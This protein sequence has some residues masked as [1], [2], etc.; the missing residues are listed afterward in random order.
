MLLVGKV[1]VALR[2]AGFVQRLP[3][4][5]RHRLEQRQQRLIVPF[6]QGREKA[7]V[8]RGAQGV[9]RAAGRAADHQVA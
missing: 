1:H 3:E 9:G 2:A 7:I 4:R 5:H 6:G 8:L